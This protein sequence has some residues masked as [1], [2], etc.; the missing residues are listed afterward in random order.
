[1]VKREQ[2][3]DGIHFELDWRRQLWAEAVSFSLP[4][5][6]PLEVRYVLNNGAAQLATPKL[7]QGPSEPTRSTPNTWQR[8]LLVG[9]PRQP[10][11]VLVNAPSSV[12]R[13]Q[14]LVCEHRFK[15]PDDVAREVEAKRPSNAVPSQSGDNTAICHTEFF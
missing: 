1:A 11:R 12:S 15:L 2:F 9:N 14:L 13:L 4:Q 3:P 7:V 6:T 10:L 8:W 5:G